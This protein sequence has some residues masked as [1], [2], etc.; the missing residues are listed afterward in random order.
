LRLPSGVREAEGTALQAPL[1]GK[2]SPDWDRLLRDGR[3]HRVFVLLTLVWIAQV[4]DLAF[5]IIAHKQGHFAELNPL[6][7]WALRYGPAGVVAFKVVLLAFGSAVLWL[8]RRRAAAECM[9]WLV[10]AVCFGLSLR[11]RDYFKIFAECGP[12]PCVVRPHSGP[13]RGSASPEPKKDSDACLA[14]WPV[15]AAESA[16]WTILRAETV[17]NSP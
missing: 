5:T 6:G 17:D 12:D 2:R 11:W 9:L 3:P 1:T 7:V 8:C 15:A 16:N 10:V 4:F 14:A 13:G